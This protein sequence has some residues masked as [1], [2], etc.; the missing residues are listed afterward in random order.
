MDSAGIWTRKRVKT[1]PMNCVHFLNFYVCLVY[2]VFFYYNRTWK[3]VNVSQNA[4]CFIIIYYKIY[5]LT[6]VLNDF[7][8]SGYIFSPQIVK[9]G[10]GRR[11]YTLSP[12]TRGRQRNMYVIWNTTINSVLINMS[13]TARWNRFWISK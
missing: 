7:V 8:V 1:L 4:V 10:G 6:T 9:E 2:V 3:F 12:T 11:G 13:H 5:S